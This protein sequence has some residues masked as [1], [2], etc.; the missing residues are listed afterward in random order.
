MTFI[1]NDDAPFFE[2]VNCASS[3]SFSHPL[4]E[5]DVDL[6]FQEL[7]DLMLAPIEVVSLEAARVRVH[8]LAS[9]DPAFIPFLH[10]LVI[11]Y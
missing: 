6:C 2:P 3:V 9:F 5:P 10:A 7:L 4:D 11:L 8:L 1:S